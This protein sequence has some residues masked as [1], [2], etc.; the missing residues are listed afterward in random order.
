MKRVIVKGVSKKFRK[1]FAGGSSLS[2]FIALFSKQNNKKPVDALKKVSFSANSGEIIGIIGKNRSG[3]STL[4]RTISGIYEP[5]SGKIE[6]N[7]KII[8]LINL[9]IGMHDRLT[10]KDNVYL[11]SSL[12]GMSRKDTKSNFNSIIEFAELKDFVDEQIYK[13]S[14]G[15]KQRLAFSIAIH[16]NPDI[17]L[18][19]EVFEVGD[20]SFKK[21]S[22]DKI[23]ELIQKGASVLLVSHDLEMIEKHLPKLIWMDKGTIKK[24][25]ATKEVLEAYSNIK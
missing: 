22:A 16:C 17:L 4:L 7:G 8:S 9:N 6:T 23:K 5:D 3:K 21:K 1:T 19:D 25:G 24:Q 13:F 2:G 11:C 10:L 18:L 14:E 20:E 12:F 15:M